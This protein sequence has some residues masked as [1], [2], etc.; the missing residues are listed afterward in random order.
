MSPFTTMRCRCL[1]AAALAAL[2]LLMASCASREEKIHTIQSKASDSLFEIKA[3]KAIEIL[4]R[5]LSKYPDSNALRVSLSSSLQSAGELGEA[6]RL[7]EEAIELDEEL[8][9]LWVKVGEIRSQLGQSEAAIQALDAYLKNHAKDFLAWKTLAQENRKLGRITDAIKAASEWN[10]I[11]PSSSPALMLGQLYQISRNFAQAR[12]WYS[13]AAAYADDF[14][15]KE[16]L[17]AL[18]SLETREKKLQQAQIWLQRFRERYG[19]QPQDARIAEAASVLENW[20]RAR[21]EIAEAAAE[22]EKERSELEAARLEAQ[23][24]A[25]AVQAAALE[26]ALQTQSSSE[27]TPTVIEEEP[28][29]SAETA[30]QRPPFALPEEEPGGA[31]APSGDAEPSAESADAIE[32]ARLSYDSEDY[33]QAISQLWQLL[34]TRPD[35]PELWSL[36]SSCYFALGSWFDAEA[37][38]LESK[39]RA[40]RSPEIANQYLQVIRKTQAP[41]RVIE[42][43]RALQRLFP[44]SA[45]I[46]LTLAQMLKDADAPKSMVASAY[47]DFL[48]K[49]GPID[50]AIPEAEL[51]LQS[52]N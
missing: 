25:A 3:D 12:S 40:P 36:L 6:A 27:Q 48:S 20:K 51:Y 43:I 4:R 15:A 47:R 39:R 42:E 17:A 37:T 52:S 2:L 49:A 28:P 32:L 8:D 7:L 14:A 45:A 46:S 34:G 10:E 13:Q 30:A 38:I 24:A 16:A 22:L 18:I 33:Q 50:P 1:H 35:D 19:D 31:T 29:P 9:H 11:T 26:T 41:K 5:G 21:R 23:R 44:R